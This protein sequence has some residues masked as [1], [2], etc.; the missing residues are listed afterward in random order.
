ML[1]H[2]LVIRGG[3][4]ADGIGGEPFEA[5]VAVH[6]GKIAEVGKISSAGKEE[7]D[8][9]GLLVTPGFVD[10]HTHY[11][12]QAAWSDRINPS[13]SLGATTVVFGNCGV[14][15]APCYPADRDLLVSLMEG[16]ED[17]PQEVLADGLEWNWRTYPEYLDALAERSYDIEVGA[18][19]PHA[20]LRVFVMGARALNGEAA[21]DADIAEMARLTGEAIN[22]GAVGFS[23]SRSINHRASNGAHTPTLVAGESELLAISKAL[24]DTG[25]GVLQIISDFD[26]VQVRP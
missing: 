13:S 9:K 11:D 23:T 1:K 25:R 8:A 10:I 2:D 24:K 3:L 7:I 6:D 22:A 21:S 20:C 19:F 12:G 14:G 4:V 5:D 16:V 26:D 15:F 17:I 18:L